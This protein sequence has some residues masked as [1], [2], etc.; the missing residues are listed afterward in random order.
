[1]LFV[2]SFIAFLAVFLHTSA[3]PIPG[4]LRNSVERR[5]TFSGGFATYF[6]QNGVA[7]A[8]GTVHSDSD[9]ISAIDVARYG[10][11]GTES[12]LCGK[13]VKITN[14][15]NQKTVTVMIADACPTCNNDNSIDLSYGA[16]TSIATEAEGMVPIT[17]EFVDDTGDASGD[18]DSSTNGND[19][20]Y[21]SSS[22]R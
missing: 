19:S 18:T 20:D 3:A 10:D 21:E 22:D 5:E 12:E 13:Y 15:N 4:H 1:M 6:W 11:T 2:S 7:G 9:M 8:C 14:T 17:W 16:F